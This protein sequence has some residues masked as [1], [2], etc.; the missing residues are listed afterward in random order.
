MAPSNCET[1]MLGRQTPMSSNASR[2]KYEQLVISFLVGGI[3]HLLFNSNRECNI[4]LE[5]IVKQAPK[6]SGKAAWVLINDCKREPPRPLF[7][8]SPRPVSK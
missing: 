7:A 5:G 6:A 4:E 2:N 8:S 3:N 1:R